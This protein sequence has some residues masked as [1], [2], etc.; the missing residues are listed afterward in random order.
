MVSHMVYLSSELRLWAR[1]RATR[2]EGLGAYLE[3]FVFLVVLL[4]LRV[5]GARFRFGGG[6]SHG[7]LVLVGRGR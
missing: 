7:V 6:A 3:L 1:N 2:F 4:G 5:F